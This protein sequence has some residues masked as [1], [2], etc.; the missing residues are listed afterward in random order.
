[1]QMREDTADVVV[2]VKCM[3]E[4]DQKWGCFFYLNDQGEHNAV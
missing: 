3:E 2:E 4:T 1:M